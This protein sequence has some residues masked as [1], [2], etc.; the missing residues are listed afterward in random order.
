MVK[1][2][3]MLK[4]GFMCLATAAIAQADVINLSAISVAQGN[5]SWQDI[6][7][8]SY[9]WNDANNNDLID[10][11]EAGQFNIVMHKTEYGRHDYDA[12]KFW[13]GNDFVWVDA[14]GNSVPNTAN[15]GASLKNDLEYSLIW[16]FVTPS[17]GDPDQPVPSGLDTKTFNIAYTFTAAGTYDL[18]ASVMCSDDLSGLYPNGSKNG[19]P[20]I[21]DFLYWDKDEHVTQLYQ[22]GNW[23]KIQ[24]ETESSLITVYAPKDVPEPTSFSLMLL[25]LTSLGG[26]LFIRRKK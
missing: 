22:F 1:R 16:D 15:G 7:N 5:T 18:T 6:Q 9:S 20:T 19:N 14:D 11:G 25:G 21:S 17:T 23:W 24:G 8:V 13:V 4:L 3:T 2:G 26:A 12:L 10:V